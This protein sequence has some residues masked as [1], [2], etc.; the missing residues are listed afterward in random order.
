MP[1]YLKLKK[2]IEAGAEFIIGQI[3]WD[4]RKYAELPAYMRAHDMGATPLIGNV[5]LMNARLAK[6]FH[7]SR[8]PGVNVCDSLLEYCERAAQSPDNG[9][10]FFLE[11]AAKQAAIFRGLGYQGVYY[12][13]VDHTHDLD[14]ILEIEKTFSPDDWKSFAL[15][16]QFSPPGTFLYY[17][18]DERTQLPDPARLN[19]DYQASL[20]V[21]RPTHNV[22]VSYRLSKFVHDQMFVP[23]KPLFNAGKKLIEHSKNPDQ[24]PKLLRALEHVGKLAMFNCKDCGDCSLPDTGYLCPESQCVKN[25]R[26][27]PCG[28]TRNGKCEIEDFEC[29]WARTYDRL[30]YE[31]RELSL[32]DHAPV[33]Q[34][35]SLRGTSSW[36]NTWRGVDH[37]SK[38][39]QKIPETKAKPS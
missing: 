7:Q 5:F 20:N 12:G 17:A 28:G 29:I 19:P 27:G 32:L 35:Q 1:Q 23:G 34:D 15:E 37:H 14:R 31:G 16:I 8:I 9:R 10:A 24:G 11:L 36:G 26:N 13:G 22:T 18:Q 21:R 2:K 25:Q 3:G 38:K 6:F 4:A 39:H 30:K 33:I